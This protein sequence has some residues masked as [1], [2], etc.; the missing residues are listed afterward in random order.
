MSHYR[1]VEPFDGGTSGSAAWTSRSATAVVAGAGRQLTWGLGG[2]RD[3]LRGWRSLARRIPDPVLRADALASLE[4]RY[5]V[6]GA[7]LFWIL[8]ARRDRELLALLVAYQTIA[9]YLDCASERGAAH[10]GAPGKSL[11]LALVDAVDVG[12]LAHDYYADHPWSDDG[13]YLAAL[14]ERCRRA[15]A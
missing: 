8:P 1:I 3:E 10:R 14:V 6:D 5:Y 12:G 11:M 2:V 7:A 13:G 15:C 4:K 9:N